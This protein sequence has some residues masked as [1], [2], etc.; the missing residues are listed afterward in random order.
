MTMVIQNSSFVNMPERAFPIFSLS[1]KNPPF[2]RS[3]LIQKF[4][5]GSPAVELPGSPKFFSKRM[6]T[7]VPE[8]AIVAAESERMVLY[9]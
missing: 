6:C 3:F 1:Y 7:F 4:A 5:P 8:Y 2:S 9:Q